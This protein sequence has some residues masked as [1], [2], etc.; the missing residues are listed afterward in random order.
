LLLL[1]LLLLLPPLL[2][3]TGGLWFVSSACFV[4]AVKTVVK[5]AIIAIARMERLITLSFSFSE[6]M[7]SLFQVSAENSEERRK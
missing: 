6:K 7:N 5:I 1:L 4:H 3:V 2:A